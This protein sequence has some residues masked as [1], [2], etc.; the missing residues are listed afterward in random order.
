MVDADQPRVGAVVLAAGGG[1]RLGGVAKALLPIGLQTFLARVV[2]LA[3]AAGV[4][5]DDIVVVVGR[6]FGD[7][8]GAAARALGAA[9]VVNPQAERGMASS[10]ALGYA[11]IAARP[12]TAAL[13]W[14]VDHARVDATTVRSLVAAGA[15]IPVHGG[16]GG[17]PALVPRA[18]F[19][20]LA[21]CA[22]AADGA[23][24]VL[25]GAL[26]RLAVDDPGVLADVDVPADLRVDVRAEAR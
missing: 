16:R 19:A 9:V 22:D 14:P 8:V 25:R 18:R 23:R 13:L 5:P 12:V 3:A 4:R 15:G 2:A 21:A 24:G 20:E 1:R 11:A 6:P 26:A 17:H 7:E 10:V